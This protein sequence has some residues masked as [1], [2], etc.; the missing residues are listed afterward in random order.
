LP[1]DD[2]PDEPLLG[3]RRFDVAAL[4]EE[5]A[6]LA[7]PISPRHAACTAPSVPD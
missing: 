4:V 1:I 3:S 5:Q 6:I 7:L 2:A